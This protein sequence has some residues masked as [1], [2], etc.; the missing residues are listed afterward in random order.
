MRKKI[1]KSSAKMLYPVFVFCVFLV[2]F[3]AFNWLPFDVQMIRD[4]SRDVVILFVLVR[5]VSR[6]CFWLE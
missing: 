6:Y 3:V 2:P 5:C 4:A 1:Q